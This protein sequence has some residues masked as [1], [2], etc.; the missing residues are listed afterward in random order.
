MWTRKLLKEKAKLDLKVCYWRSVLV[1]AILAFAVG[2]ASGSSVKSNAEDVSNKIN[3]LGLSGTEIAI[4]LAA[5][6]AVV[7]VALVAGTAFKIFLLNPISVGCKKFFYDGTDEAGAE[8]SDLSYSFKNNYLNQVLVIFLRNLFVALWSLLLVIPGIIKAYQYRM[9]EY[10]ISENPD[11]NYKDALAMSKEMMDGNKWAAFELDLSFIL[12]YLLSGLTGGILYI[13]YVGPYV[14][15]TNAELY[16]ALKNDG[17]D[18]Y[19]ED[20]VAADEVF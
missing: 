8:L 16:A 3:E 5:V 13:F 10:I 4:I 15:Y 18:T 20:V 6:L 17:V 7:S 1:S 11:M 19:A 12:W 2:G 9:V 14:N